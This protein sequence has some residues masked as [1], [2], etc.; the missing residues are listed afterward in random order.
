MCQVPPVNG[1]GNPGYKTRGLVA[2]QK[3]S[4]A[5]Q[6]LCLAEPTEGRMGNDGLAPLGVFPGFL[7]DQK[8]LVLFA[9]EKT[10]CNRIYPDAVAGKFIARL[11]KAGCMKS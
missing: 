3:Q 8:R 7:I 4:S 2:G 1:N 6:F 5:D 9:D 11:L 10:G